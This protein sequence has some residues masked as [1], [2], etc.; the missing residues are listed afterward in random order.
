MIKR[1]PALVVAAALAAACSPSAPTGPHQSRTSPV[2][3]PAIDTTLRVATFNVSLYGQANGDVSRQLEAGDERARKIAAIIQHLAP[4]IV[5]LNEFDHDASGETAD[6]FVRDYLAVP[7]ADQPAIEYPHRF[8][9]PVNT[10]VPS[11]FDLDRDGRTDGPGDAWGYGTHPGQ[12]GM[13]LLSRHPIDAG[14]SR[15]FRQLRWKDLP[16]ALEVQDPET[17]APWYPGPAWEQFPLS[18]KSHWDVVVETP[19]GRVHVL[20]AHPTPPAFDGP[21]GRN[22]LRNHDEIRLWAE[23]IGTGEAQWLVDDAGRS[24]RLG[25][26]VAFVI[27]GDYNADPVDGASHDNAIAQLLSHPRVL[28]YPP[29][30]SAGAVVAA[31]EQ[32]GAN[33]VHLGDPAHDTGNFNP[34]TGN[35]RVDYVLPSVQFEVVDSGVYWPPADE[36]ALGASEASDHHLVWADLRRVPSGDDGPQAP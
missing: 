6:R 26:D 18:S 5:L 21:E 30:R 9:A 19:L 23:Y 28:D 25:A 36:D 29:P 10:G 33:A 1:L 20:A 7:Q 17:G 16:G 15:T 3:P 11:G 27:L 2:T 32:G 22:R 4:D 31:R 34:R 13:L 24:G 14:A 35:L 12:Y 8:L